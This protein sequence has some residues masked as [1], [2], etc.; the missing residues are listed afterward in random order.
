MWT[1]AVEGARGGDRRAGR[2]E[3]LGRTQGSEELHQRATKMLPAG[4]ASNF[5]AGDPYPVYL[6]HGKGSTVW[7]VDGSEYTDFH[8]G[9]G[10]N[11]VGHAHP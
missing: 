11:V 9:F 7:D 3:V 4:V 2:K 6:R 10:V 1:S 5:Q 8:G